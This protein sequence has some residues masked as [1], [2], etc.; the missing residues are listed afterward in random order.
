[1]KQ[2][3]RP[4]KPRQR[5]LPCN[6]PLNVCDEGY[7]LALRLFEGDATPDDLAKRDAVI[8][9]LRQQLTGRSACR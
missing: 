5:R 4:Y 6:E 7:H 8:D 9:K 3:R 1:M 2:D